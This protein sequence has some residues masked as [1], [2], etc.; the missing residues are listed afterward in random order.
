MQEELIASR[1][2]GTGRIYNI[3][4]G[5]NFLKILAGAIADGRIVPG[6]DPLADPVVLA[7]TLVYL[8][9]RRAARA[10]SR[11]L[12]SAIRDRTGRKG[13]VLPKIRTIG[14]IDEEELLQGLGAD[15]PTGLGIPVA[16]TTRLLAL[17]RLVLHWARSMQPETRDLFDGEPVLMPSSPADAIA[18]AARLAEV[19]DQVETEEAEWQAIRDIVPGSGPKRDW[20][21]VTLSF[22]DIVM[23]HWPHFLAGRGEVS[24][25]EHRRRV[26]EYRIAELE[27]AP[28]KGPV[29]AAGST[30]SIPATAR[31]IARISRLPSGAVVLPGFDDQLPDEAFTAFTLASELGRESAMST[32]PQFGLSRLLHSLGARPE[33]VMQA[34]PADPVLNVRERMI[35]IALLPPAMSGG[36]QET[37]KQFSGKAVDAAFAGVTLVEAPGERQE[38]LAIALAMRKVLETPDRTA[39]LVTPDRNLARRVSSELGRFG[40]AVDDSGGTPVI[41]SPAALVARL[42]LRVALEG[43]DPV[44]MAGFLRHDSVL[45]GFEPAE[46]RLLAERL[47]LA[48]VREAHLSPQPERL[49]D[50][51]RSR[52]MEIRKDHHAHPALKSLDDSAWMKLAEFG[53]AV[54]R[55]LVPLTALRGQPAIGVHALIET[56]L[57]SVLALSMNSGG[58]ATLAEV[59]GHDELRDAALAFLEAGKGEP[60]TIAATEA[61]AVFDRLISGI[62]LR[63]G[64]RTHPRLQIYG[65]LEARLQTADLVILGGLNEGIWPPA[66]MNDP[67]LNRPMRSA[68][69]LPLPERRTGLAAHDFCQFAGMPEVMMTRAKRSGDA[70]SVASRWLQR[71][72]AF[73]GE[74]AMAPLR[75]RGRRFLNLARRIDEPQEP[76]QRSPRP[77]PVPPV[78]ARPNRLSFTEIE[79]WIRDPYAIYARHVLGLRPLPQIAPRDDVM[80]RGTLYHAILADHVRRAAEMAADKRLDDLLETARR[81]LRN[82]NLPAE[83]GQLWESRFTEIAVAF[84]AWESSR[85]TKVIRSHCEIPGRLDLLQGGFRLSGIA[86]RIDLLSDG[87]YCIIDY[88]TG[89]GPSKKQARTLS[90]QLALEG[91]ALVAGGFENVEGGDVSGLLYVRLRAGGGF[92]FDDI[93]SGRDADGVTPSQLIARKREELIQ[94]IEAYRKPEQGYLSRYAPVFETEPANEY[95]HLARV[96]EWSL[97]DDEGDEA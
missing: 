53:E 17:A 38:A 11:E 85:E 82:A 39:I 19:M 65:Q 35:N 87:K 88:K 96:R 62:A 31:L 26:I 49:G 80:L 40:I 24:P 13:I 14:D 54:S 93:T 89:T 45:A 91:A 79:T 92:R 2:E 73:L 32:H 61:C 20:W 4:P 46:A 36:W 51:V 1:Q 34:A 72:I 37:R 74:D 7:D 55:A 76:A 22:L 42:A 33:M 84:I 43:F 71:I 86:D 90:P 5:Q 27:R 70:P 77:C 83:T 56:V 68:L 6:F 64:A 47:E 12:A 30:G 52:A 15:V 16:R 8:P 21:E 95:D 57:G 50:A 67:F 66:A 29:I 78:E 44:A 23:R 59:Q 94:L 97:G 63:N 75:Q 18:F 25:A 58:V 69:N 10:F 28:P 9:T 3:R 60:L 48:V 41:S 81:Y